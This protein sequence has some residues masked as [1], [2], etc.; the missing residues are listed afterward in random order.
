MVFFVLA[1]DKVKSVSFISIDDILF[2]PNRP[3]PAIVSTCLS[4]RVLGRGTTAICWG[5]I[6]RSHFFAGVE[7]ANCQFFLCRVQFGSRFD[8]LHNSCKIL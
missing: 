8:V 6:N 4:S 5:F 7:N 2:G 3:V 1:V